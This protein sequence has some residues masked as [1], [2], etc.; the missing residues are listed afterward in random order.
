MN[1]IKLIKSKKFIQLNGFWYKMLRRIWH[2]SLK[3]EIKFEVR[4]KIDRY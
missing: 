4:V 1:K 2:S 3:F